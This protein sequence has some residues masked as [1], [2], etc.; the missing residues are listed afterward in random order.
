MKTFISSIE[1]RAA[2]YEDVLCVT[3]KVGSNRRKLDA[4]H[5]HTVMN[6]IN[7]TARG[8]KP[9]DMFASSADLKRFNEYS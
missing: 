2:I 1:I 5:Q 6:S 3:K 9:V 7:N 4:P 8:Y